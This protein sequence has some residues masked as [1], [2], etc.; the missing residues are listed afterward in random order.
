MFLLSGGGLQNAVSGATPFVDP[1]DFGNQEL[2][3]TA[4]DRPVE[5]HR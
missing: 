5:P 2:T 3:P 1:A 4:R